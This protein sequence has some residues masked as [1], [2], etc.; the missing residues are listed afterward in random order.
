MNI[1]PLE[2]THRRNF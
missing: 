1:L 2:D